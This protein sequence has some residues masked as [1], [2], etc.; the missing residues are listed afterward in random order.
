MTKV[1]AVRYDNGLDYSDHWE[2][3]VKLCSTKEKAEAYIEAE[4]QKDYFEYE[5]PT[6]SITEEEVL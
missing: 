6:W 2:G 1:F 5:N 4:K 3:I